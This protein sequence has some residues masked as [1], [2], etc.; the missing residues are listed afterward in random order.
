MKRIFFISILFMSLTSCERIIDIDPISNVGA[1]AFYRNYKEANTALTGCYQGM[2]APLHNEWM[3]TELRSDLSLQG[4]PNTSAV[5]RLEQNE[6]DMFTL[7]ADHNEVYTYWINTY[8]NIRRSEE[9]T[10]E[11]QSREN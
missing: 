5:P 3:M 11:L 4:V 8:R 10:S 1:G 2:H 7:N 6:L 9:H